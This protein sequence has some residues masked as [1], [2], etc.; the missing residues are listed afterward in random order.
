M[1]QVVRDEVVLVHRGGRVLVFGLLQR[2]EEHI[3]L[4]VLQV[5]DAF[6]LARSMVETPV[7]KCNQNF[8][9]RIGGVDRQR[10]V[11]R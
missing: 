6:A 9:T 11:S 5:Q 7:T 8:I 4:S 1:E 3:E 2:H 10:I